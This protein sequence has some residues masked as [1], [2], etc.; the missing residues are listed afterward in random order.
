MTF[1]E[2][3]V[4][5]NTAR[6]LLDTI[7]ALAE[8]C[9]RLEAE[10]GEW[11]RVAENRLTQIHALETH[12]KTV[13]AER[14]TARQLTD[15]VDARVQDANATLDAARREHS[16]EYNELSVRVKALEDARAK[17]ENAPF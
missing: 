16:K 7:Q 4:Q 8:R 15:I 1:E 5:I 10:A 13:A 11:H 2:M 6:T 14:D 12:L 17:D 9:E 3:G